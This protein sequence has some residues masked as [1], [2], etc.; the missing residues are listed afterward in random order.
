MLDSILE[1]K[2]REIEKPIKKWLKYERRADWIVYSFFI[3]VVV[4]IVVAIIRGY[5]LFGEV[6]ASPEQVVSA[7]LIFGYI[8]IAFY[9]ATLVR[10][11]GRVYRPDA[12]DV[13]LYYA[14]SI[15][16]TLEDYNKSKRPILKE[17]HRK[18]AVK[19]A[20]ELLSTVRE[21][22]ALGDFRLAKKV[23]GDT[24]SNISDTLSNRV[25]P[26]LEKGDDETLEKVEHAIY[27]FA[28]YLL[29]PSIDGLQN[30]NKSMSE[31]LKS[32]E[33]EKLGFFGRCSSFFATHAILKHSTIV[34]LIFITS[35]V[36]A[37]L[38]LHFWQISTDSAFLGFAAIFASSIGAYFL[39]VLRRE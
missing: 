22:W 27:Q 25:I 39:Y 16:N 20:K 33:S 1:G 5:S 18:K 23:Y 35:F 6:V 13:I 21:D 31:H 36:P 11:K 32:Y 34:V 29:R 15:L 30:A 3:A 19:S 38:G 17:E 37:L 4:W 28:Q 12:D 24:I 8:V 14:C 26:N 10:K 9:S 2:Y 7:F